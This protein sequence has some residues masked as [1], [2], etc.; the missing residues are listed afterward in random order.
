VKPPRLE[1]VPYGSL[2]RVP[3]LFAD[4]MAGRAGRG[5]LLPPLPRE[6]AALRPHLEALL[7]RPLPRAEVAAVLEAQNRTFGADAAALTGIAAL[8]EPGSVAVLTG[9]QVGLFGGP[10]YTWYKA[11]TAVVVARH[12][13]EALKVPC[14]PCFWL[15]S[16]DDD[17][18]EVDHALLLTRRSGPVR[19][20]Y[21]PEGGFANTL[22]ATCRL[23]AAIVPVLA[24]AAVTLLLRPDVIP[25]YSDFFWSP[26]LSIVIAVNLVLGTIHLGVHE[27]AHLVAARAEGIPAHI[28]PGTRLQHLVL[29]TDVS[30]AWAL[31]RSSRYRIYLAG[32]LWDLLALSILILALAYAGLP[33]TGEALLA[34]WILLIFFGLLGE[35]SFYMRT[36]IYFVF[37]D[38][39]HSRNLF[40][41]AQSLLLHHYRRAIH[42]LHPKGAGLPPGP[43]LARSAGERRKVVFYACLLITGTLISLGRYLLIGIPIL[44][45]LVSQAAAGLIGGFQ[46]GN[47]FLVLDSS[48]TL[49]AV[50]G[51]QAL[52]VATFLHGRRGAL[53]SISATLARLFTPHSGPQRDSPQSDS[54]PPALAP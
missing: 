41:D 5:D 27:L 48:F 49:L 9:Q 13:G 2:R 6:P 29:Q 16:E 52:F 15:A 21:Q 34:A 19:V 39:L 28:R 4:A 47:T 23:T 35:F 26:L 37:Q 12:W 51:M 3:P 25:R 54:P 20:Q 33:P 38:L 32:V 43:L 1:P 18:T 14:V 40:H 36:D 53:A 42:A 30:A 45:G 44:L 7:R 46:I 24:A 10:L 11:L 50:V 17:F 31:P 22:P 8:R